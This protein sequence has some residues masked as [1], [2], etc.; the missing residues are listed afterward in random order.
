MDTRNA[1]GLMPARALRL[2]HQRMALFG[3]G[4]YVKSDACEPILALRA[5]ERLA[6]NVGHFDGLDP[7]GV[8]IAELGRGAQP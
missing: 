4:R 2:P 7:L 6:E 3:T 8:L 1:R 5:P